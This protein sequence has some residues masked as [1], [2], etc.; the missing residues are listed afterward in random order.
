MMMQTGG[1]NSP[2]GHLPLSKKLLELKWKSG[3]VLD[4]VNGDLCIG[5]NG[6]NPVVVMEGYQDEI[7]KR[8]TDNYTK[9][10]PTIL[11][12]IPKILTDQFFPDEY[13]KGDLLIASGGKFKKAPCG[14]QH[15]AIATV[16]A[17]KDIRKSFWWFKKETIMCLEILFHGKHKT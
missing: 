13:K 5:D 7:A 3:M 1:F 16:L 17:V 2:R 6:D 15:S 12:P 10:P 11:F 9:Y 4:V 8:R 14:Y